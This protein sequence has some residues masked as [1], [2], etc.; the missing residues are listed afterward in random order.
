MKSRGFVIFSLEPE[1]KPA[2]S[3]CDHDA[4]KERE[5]NG[6]GE[7]QIPAEVQDLEDRGIPGEGSEPISRKSL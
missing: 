3:L 5:S 6:N 1:C 4:G 7:T 2:I